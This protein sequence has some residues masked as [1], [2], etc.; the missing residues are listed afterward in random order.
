M[1][2]GVVRCGFKKSEKPTVRFSEIVKPTVRF[3][4][5]FE[6]RK[7]LRFGSV[8]FNVLRCGS[9]RFSK[10]GKTYG[11]VGCGFQMT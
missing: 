5:V 8:L 7:N 6:N 9:V 4:A 2:Y 11:A 3:G 1:S 10:I